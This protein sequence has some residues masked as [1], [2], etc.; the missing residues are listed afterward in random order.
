MA[1]HAHE[2]AYKFIADVRHGLNEYSA[3]LWAG[4]DTSG[5][6]SNSYI[7]DKLNAAQAR[8]YALVMKSDVREIFYESA[9]VTVTSSV[10]TLPWDYGK[11]LQLEDADGYKVWPSTARITPVTGEEGSD[12]LYYRDGNTLV[13]NKTG[14]SDTYT[15]KYFKKPRKMA[16]GAAAAT[17]GLNSL[18]L[19]ATVDTVLRDDYYNNLIFDNYTQ[20]KYATV[21]DFVASTR[22]ATTGTS[23][24]AVTWAENDVYG[25]VPDMPEEFHNLIAPL[26]I[27]IIKAEHPAAQERPNQAEISMWSEALMEV[28]AAFANQPDDIPIESIFCDLAGFGGMTGISV[29]G[30]GYLIYD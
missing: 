5:K 8:I 29:P 23:P 27:I 9:S 22:T 2:N 26:T 10:I 18:L 24:G 15:L 13:L 28:M 4:S 16:Y 12:N 17:S 6:F 19:A 20:G 30:Q 25:S 14:V 7:L 1:G 21:S 11:I 3:A